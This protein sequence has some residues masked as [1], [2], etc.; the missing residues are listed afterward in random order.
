PW[1]GVA[2][3]AGAALLLGRWL[4]GH[5]V[6]WRLLRNAE[7]APQAVERLFRKVASGRA[8]PRLLVSQRLRVPMSCGLLRPAVVV[9]SAL[10]EPDAEQA[11]RWVFAHEL[12]HLERRDA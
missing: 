10:C 8:R 3:L 11:L 4:F 9:P 12:T 1:L 6:L 2:Y 5:V 7:P